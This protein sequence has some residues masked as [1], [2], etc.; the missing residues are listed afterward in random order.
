[1][2]LRVTYFD[3]RPHHKRMKAQGEIKCHNHDVQKNETELAN[4]EENNHVRRK[5]LSSG[6]LQTQNK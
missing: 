2:R 3:N 6:V 4:L 5:V 1:M